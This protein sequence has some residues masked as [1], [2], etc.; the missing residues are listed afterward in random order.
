MSSNILDSLSHD[1]V[2]YLEGISSPEK[3]RLSKRWDKEKDYQTYGLSAKAYTALYEVFNPRFTALTHQQRLC[4]A[5]R[6]A[7]TNNSTLTHL[8]I[9]LLR[10]STKTREMGPENFPF[11]NQ[12]LEH[13]RGWGNTDLI[14]GAVLQPLLER[15]PDET[16]ALLRRWNAS[17][18]PMK[19][20]ASVVVF[21]RKTA[22][23]G[24]YVVLTLELCDKLIWDTEDLV[25]KGVGWAL[26]DTMR[27]DKPKVLDYVKELR[28][29]G[30][31]ST[32]TLYAIRDIK[33]EQRQEI[34]N[35][36]PPRASMKE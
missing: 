35:I 24:R 20:R 3:V 23:S 12:F 6:W 11:L 29:K 5:E 28:R 7:E 13:L 19:R 26:K 2:K 18:H 15:H 22:E 8:G 36:K 27:A 16:I 17:D 34:L 21:T 4:L 32:I 9:H 10:L 31:S 14:C 33:G 1:V 30:V 25:R